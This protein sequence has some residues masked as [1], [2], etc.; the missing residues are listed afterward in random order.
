MKLM[1]NEICQNFT[2]ELPNLIANLSDLLDF[3]SRSERE[4]GDN[5]YGCSDQV[6]LKAWS[7]GTFPCTAETVLIVDLTI[8]V[9]NAWAWGASVKLLGVSLECVVD[10]GTAHVGSEASTFWVT[11][12]G[13]KI[14]GARAYCSGQ[15]NECEIIFEHFDNIYFKN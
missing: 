1:S 8:R 11:A 5:C 15:K 4:C 13:A 12:L 10:V 6:S 7:K 3:R 14:F 2:R 9:L